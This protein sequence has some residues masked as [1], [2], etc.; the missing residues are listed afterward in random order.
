HVDTYLNEFVFRYN[1]RF[2]RHVSFETLLGLIADKEPT[3][4]WDLIKRD[5]PRKSVGCE[6]RL[7]PQ[8]LLQPRRAEPAI[9]RSSKDSDAPRFTRP[10]ARC[11]CA[12]GLGGGA[13][14][15]PSWRQPNEQDCRWRH[16]LPATTRETRPSSSLVVSSYRVSGGSRQPGQRLVHE[17]LW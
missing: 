7:Q 12:R 4:Y 11:L 17:A 3:S 1:R 8:R 15:A 9:S 6:R 16:P 5:N 10:A 2:Y 13:G 14:G